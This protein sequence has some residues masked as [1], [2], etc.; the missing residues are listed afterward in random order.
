MSAYAA[1]TRG[2]G[3]A[4]MARG[5]GSF[6]GRGALF[7]GRGQ[8]SPLAGKESETSERFED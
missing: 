4:S 3:V 5:R 8:S 6:M 7:G 1:A 2:R